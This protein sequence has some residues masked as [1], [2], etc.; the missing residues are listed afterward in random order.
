SAPSRMVADLPGRWAHPTDGRCSMIGPPDAAP[1]FC[2]RRAGAKA[3][4]RGAAER[5]APPGAGGGMAYDLLIRNATI[6]DGTGGPRRNGAV[7]VQDGMIQA[8][9][10]VS[11]EA[12]R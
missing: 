11:G 8:V 12:K 5:R 9:G 4:G 10:E 7:A 3:D 6:V 1:G 2:S